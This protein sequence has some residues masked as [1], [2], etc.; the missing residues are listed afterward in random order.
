[1]KKENRIKHAINREFTAWWNKDGY[2]Y[3]PEN[4]EEGE[5]CVVVRYWAWKGFE[6]GRTMPLNEYVRILLSC[7]KSPWY[8]RIISSIKHWLGGLRNG[9]SRI[10][11]R[12]RNDCSL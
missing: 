8:Y 1:M 11:N 7:K 6:A 12:K 2:N 3:I 5:W 4:E 9:D 10:R